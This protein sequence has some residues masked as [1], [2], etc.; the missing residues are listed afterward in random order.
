MDKIKLVD[1]YITKQLVETFLLGVIIFTSIMF[2]SDAFLNLVKQITTFGISFQVA[3][4]LIVLKLP[5]I[6]VYTI[7]MA[8]LLSTIIT[9]N[10]L[11]TSQEITIMR[12]CGISIARISI[13]VF[14]FGLTAALCSFLLNEFIVPSA[15]QQAKT[16]SIWA[17]NQKNIPQGKSNFS[18]KELDPNTNQL[19]RLFYFDSYKNKKMQGVTVLD[20]SKKGATQII[21]AKHATAN[22]AYW[23]FENAVAYTISQSN[24]I[25]NTT[26]FSSL[27]MFSGFNPGQ[28]TINDKSQELNFIGLYKFIKNNKNIESKKLAALVIDLNEKFALPLTSMFLTLVGIPLAITKPRAKFNRGLLFSIFV[29]FCYYIL[30]ALSS[31]MGESMIIPPILAAWLPNIIIVS[32]GSILFYRK[33]FLI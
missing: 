16:L 13:P 6:I 12:A 23:G 33:A 31:S 26:I 17:L 1:T 18:L 8:V 27:K 32:V 5:F 10:K 24:S 14:I 20:L 25:M 11:S 2:A 15:N 3:F 22:P 19:K 9:V 29:I 7:P 4:V 21:Q 30:R 28:K